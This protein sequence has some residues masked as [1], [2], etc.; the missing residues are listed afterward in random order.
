MPLIFSGLQNEGYFD[1]WALL[2]AMRKKA[3]SL[4]AVFVKGEAVG[5]QYKDGAFQYK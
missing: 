4:G 5:F 1:P 2:C 3:Q